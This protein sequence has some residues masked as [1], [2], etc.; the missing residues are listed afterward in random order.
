MASA[1]F[2]HI[3]A[4]RN[5]HNLVTCATTGIVLKHDGESLQ[6]AAS[7]G[8]SSFALQHLGP[9]EAS[10]RVGCHLLILQQ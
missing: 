6:Q 4:I 5:K 9:E 3:Q 2:G 7:T 8:A 1:C 10:L